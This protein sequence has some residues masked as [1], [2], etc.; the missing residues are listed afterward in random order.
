MFCKYPSIE[1]SYRQEFLTKI[2]EHGYDRATYVVQEKAHGANLS[3]WTNDGQTFHAGKRSGPLAAD[4]RFY[5]FMEVVETATPAL[6]ALWTELDATQVLTQLTVF[7][8]L[9]GGHY[10]HPDVPQN[11]T[12]IKTQ[13][14]VFYAPGNHF[15]A[16]DLLLGRETFVDVP[17]ATALFARYGLLHARTLYAGTLRECLAHS[18]AFDSTVPAA[19]GLPPLTPNVCEGV[20]IR[21]EQPLFFNNG[22]RVILK[23]KNERWAERIKPIKTVE[24]HALTEEVT[25]L[26][27]AIL[28]YVTENRLANVLSKLGPVDRSNFG[29]AL[30]LFNA[31]VLADFRKNY[32]TALDALDKKD[33][34]RVTNAVNTVAVK[35]VRRHRI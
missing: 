4:E 15:Y 19:L 8:E 22:T 9:I 18:N 16:F 35:L 21:P 27:T 11:R 6:R 5:N 2:A 1:N 23:N 12:A 20:V 14:G 33:R 7:G 32:G 10:P 34:K 17:T 3:I 28:G 13:K 31:D 24:D 30:R 29:E 26:Q 25:R